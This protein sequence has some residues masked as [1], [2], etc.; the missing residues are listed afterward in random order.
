[1]SKNLNL[2][3]DKRSGSTVCSRGAVDAMVDEL[4]QLMADHCFEQAQELAEDIDADER[5]TPEHRTTAG[6]YLRQIMRNEEAES[7]DWN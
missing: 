6:V 5:A 7:W 3:K 2:P 4:H 1:M